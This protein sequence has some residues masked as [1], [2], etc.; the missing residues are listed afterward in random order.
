ML[1]NPRAKARTRTAATSQIFS[2]KQNR[3]VLERLR[4]RCCLLVDNHVAGRAYA[5]CSMGSAFIF[6]AA[7]HRRTLL[8]LIRPP[9]TTQLSAKVSSFG[10]VSVAGSRIL[11]GDNRPTPGTGG[12]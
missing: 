7:R 10:A 9:T 11:T 3:T 2:E 5:D 6:E 12:A 4:T 8:R 1:L